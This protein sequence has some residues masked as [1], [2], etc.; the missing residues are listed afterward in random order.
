LH[1]ALADSR[2]DPAFEPEPLTQHDLDVVAG[3]I[4]E[5]FRGARRWLRRTAE[6]DD[7]HAAQQARA[8]LDAEKRLGPWLRESRRAAGTM[9]RIRI[10]GDYH[11]GQVLDVDG[12]FAIIDFGGE[13]GL[14]L[15]ERRRKAS[16]FADVAGMIRSFSYAGLTAR[17]SRLLTM[18]EGDVPFERIS[19]WVAWWEERA[20]VA[21]LAAYLEEAAGEPFLPGPGDEGQ[22]V[23]DL[24]LL[25]KAL[26]ELHYE[27]E[28]RPEWAF[29]P[30][31][32]LATIAGRI[33]VAS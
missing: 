2:G 8:V 4:R 32:G 13:V 16:V 7:M 27:M 6:G 30:L 29:I 25:D 14:P 31:E 18:P 5:R 21:F 26:H 23:L 3:R 1:R 19:G 9:H 15:E 11:L 12:R 33:G 17:A 10:H 22:L 20:M 28:Y 24:Y